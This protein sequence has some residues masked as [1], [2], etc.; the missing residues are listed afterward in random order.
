[1]EPYK[2]SVII[3]I[4]LETRK[5]VHAITMITTARTNSF[6]WRIQGGAASACPPTQRDPILSYSHT[7]PPKSAHIGG[8]CPPPPPN[9]KSWIRHCHFKVNSVNGIFPPTETSLPKLKGRHN[10]TSY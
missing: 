6:H 4:Y 9:G 1:M 2:L 10:K 7:F 3:R 8:R 5:S